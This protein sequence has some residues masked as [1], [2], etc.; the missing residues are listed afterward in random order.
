[1]SH[2]EEYKK[3]GTESGSECTFGTVL[4]GLLRSVVLPF[5]VTLSADY[6]GVSCYGDGGS[7]DT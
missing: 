7:L 3:T 2:K 4:G 1:M 5:S 6:D